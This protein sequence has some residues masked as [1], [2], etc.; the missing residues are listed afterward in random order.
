MLK[1]I[2]IAYC[3]SSAI[4]AKS[5]K[6][7]NKVQFD[8]DSKALRI[9]NCATRSISPYISDFVTPPVPMNNRKVK[10]IGGLMSD[11]MIGTIKWSIEDDEGQVH[12][13]VLPESIYLKG[14]TSR[15]LSPQHWAQIAKDNHPKP[16]GTWCATYHDHVVLHW[17]QQQYKRTI[18]LDKHGTNVATIRTAPGYTAYQSF[19]TKAELQEDDT[20]ALCYDSNLISDSEDER[21]VEEPESETKETPEFYVRDSP[22]VTDFRGTETMSSDTLPVVIDDEEDQ[23]PSNRSA[24]FLQWHHRLG[25]LSPKKMQLMARQGLLPKFLADCRVP[26]CTSCMYG[27]ATRRRWRNKGF[28]NSAETSKVITQPGEC[29]SIDQLESTTPGLIGQL[30]G[31]PTKARYQVA[32]IFVDHATRFGYVHLQKSTSAEDT[33]QAKVAFE[34][35]AANSGVKILHYHA[36]NGIF[37]DNKFRKAVADAGQTLTFCGVNAHFQNGVAERRI[38][39]LQNHARTMLIHASNRWPSAITTNLWP[40]ALRMAND[41]LNDTPNLVTSK[42]PTNHFTRSNIA[43]NPKHYHTFGCPMYMLDTDLQSGKRINKWSDRSNVGIHL[44]RSSQHA[45]TVHLVLS[46]TTGLLSP[47]FHLKVDDKFETLRTVYGNHPPKSL[48]QEKC[49]FVAKQSPMQ[50]N[51]NVTKD[52]VTQAGK[53]QN[54]TQVN[55]S[56]PEPIQATENPPSEPM[57]PSE[58]ASVVPPLAPAATASSPVLTIPSVP[59]QSVRRSTRSRRSPQRLIEAYASEL[60]HSDVPYEV[61]ATLH[62]D[63]DHDWCAY[64]ASKDPDTMYLHEAMKQPDKAEFLV[65]MDKEMQGQMDNGNFKVVHQSE[66]PQGASILPAVWAMRRKRRIAT[67]LRN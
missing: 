1:R 52:T 3:M 42:I 49:H 43:V 15:L 36:D 23:V 58:G 54:S 13:I 45:R 16:H 8:T 17:K 63:D 46:L 35:Q 64:A 12:D 41:I 65:A 40:Y 55:K 56:A 2:T 44:G 18:Q 30:R 20:N 33:I 66:V 24:E 31:T 29:V 25:H 39:E 61:F 50:G 57:R 48:W 11:V 67:M 59:E 10:G 51:G 5:E 7:Q 27:K 9:D 26:L 14:G 21:E 28:N 6:H 4:T 37:A 34:Q 47:Q 19:C 53:T 60:Q 62:D 32:T 22:L 38:R